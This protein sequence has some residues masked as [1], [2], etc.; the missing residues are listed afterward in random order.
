MGIT[1]VDCNTIFKLHTEAMSRNKLVHI[2]RPILERR[3]SPHSGTTVAPGPRL[4]F[5]RN[6]TVSMR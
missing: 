5:N 3:S 4:I 2:T 1:A 6:I